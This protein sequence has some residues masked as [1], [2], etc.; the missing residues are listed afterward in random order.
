MPILTKPFSAQKLLCWATVAGFVA[1]ICGWKAGV[2]AGIAAALG[3]L[4]VE[5][6]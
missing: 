2:V 1:L 5:R 3:L 4:W 6:E